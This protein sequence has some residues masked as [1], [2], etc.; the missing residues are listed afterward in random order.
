MDREKLMK[1][2]GEQLLDLGFKKGNSLDR[3][4]NSYLYYGKE[5]LGRKNYMTTADVDYYGYKI[6]FFPREHCHYTTIVNWEKVVKVDAVQALYDFFDE[7][8]LPVNTE[9]GES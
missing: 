1:Q 3:D 2:F 5:L 9:V 8:Y 4:V 7:Y 6:R